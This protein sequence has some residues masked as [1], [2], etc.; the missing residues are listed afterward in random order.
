MKTSSKLHFLISTLIMAGALCGCGD[1]SST[2]EAPAIPHSDEAIVKG[3]M[4]T[5]ELTERPQV[6]QSMSFTK[7]VFKTLNN[8]LY[9][10]EKLTR[11][12][13]GVQGDTV[14]LEE[15]RE[16]FNEHYIGNCGPATASRAAVKVDASKYYRM[17]DVI[18][19][20]V[21]SW[22]NTTGNEA[23]C[24][25]ETEQIDHIFKVKATGRCQSNNVN[26]SF[27]D[28]DEVRNFE[29]NIKYPWLMPI[30]LKESGYGSYNWRAEAHPAPVL[31]ETTGDAFSYKSKT[32][33]QRQVQTTEESLLALKSFFDGKVFEANDDNQGKEF[34]LRSDENVENYY[35][36]D[37]LSLWYTKGCKI[38]EYKKLGDIFYNLDSKEYIISKETINVVEVN[39]DHENGRTDE[40][41][42]VILKE[43]IGADIEL[44]ESLLVLELSEIY[45]TLFY[46]TDIYS[47]YSDLASSVR[48]DQK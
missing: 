7:D 11:T 39:G 1:S 40:E 17:K 35:E 21:N 29:F 3:E 18:S 8:C 43:K 6:G 10:N 31:W 30:L 47:I 36:K 5:S 2:S 19:F 23:D 33:N 41:C 22:R 26:P 42:Q 46:R 4:I 14:I 32:I 12:V 16:L 45:D 44:E 37:Y 25:I 24:V 9:E 48:Y 15:V 38:F 28:R 20:F 13:V 34:A 27:G